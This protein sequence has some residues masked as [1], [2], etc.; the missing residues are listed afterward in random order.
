[1]RQAKQP[2]QGIIG[3]ARLMAEGAKRSRRLAGA[4]G[5]LFDSL[6][7]FVMQAKHRG[8]EQVGGAQGFS[9]HR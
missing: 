5:S 2:T 6:L 1:M 3:Q 8:A 9:G 4:A 7:K